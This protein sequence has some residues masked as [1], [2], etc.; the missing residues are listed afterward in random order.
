MQMYRKRSGQ[1]PIIAAYQ[2]KV[3]DPTGAPGGPD[4][5][6]TDAT[7]GFPTCSD[8]RS[9]PLAAGP[10]AAR[11]SAIPA[12]RRASNGNGP[13]HR[14]RG[15]AFRERWA[16]A[17]PPLGEEGDWRC[18]LDCS[19]CSLIELK[20]AAIDP[21]SIDAIPMNHLHGGHFGGCHS[22]SWTPSSTPAETGRCSWR[23]MPTCRG[24]CG[25]AAGS[26]GCQQ[27]SFP[28]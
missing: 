19:A 14:Q 23:A 2:G 22:S 3:S 5:M 10:G 25:R 11:G 1:R 9:R 27:R 21:A 17:D 12:R 28:R 20:A 15:D 8:C 13:V 16:L 6:G 26:P 18:L 4:N 24:G 7:S